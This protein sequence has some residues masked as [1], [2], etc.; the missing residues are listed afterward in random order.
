MNIP[1]IRLDRAGT[2]HALLQSLEPPQSASHDAAFRLACS[3][4]RNRQSA[5]DVEA[6][7]EHKGSPEHRP[8]LPT[9]R[10]A[11]ARVVSTAVRKDTY[12]TDAASQ[13]FKKPIASQKDA[14]SKRCTRHFPGA[15]REGKRSACTSSCAGHKSTTWGKNH[16]RRDEP[17]LPRSCTIPTMYVHGLNQLINQTTSSKLLLRVHPLLP[18]LPRPLAPAKKPALPLLP[19]LSSRLTSHRHLLLLQPPLQF[20]NPPLQRSQLSL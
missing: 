2:R 12:A 5:T 6:P 19:S 8:R 14:Q 15:K 13:G 20:P 4:K 16:T 7:A 11:K 17:D 3:A 9:E 10:Q 1:R 18:P